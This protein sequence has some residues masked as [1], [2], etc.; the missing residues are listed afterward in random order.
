MAA[1][2]ITVL[3]A[4]SITVR[5]VHGSSPTI[6]PAYHHGT[7]GKPSRP[8]GDS[9]LVLVQVSEASIKAE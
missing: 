8:P 7:S 6:G 5:A 3:V 2:H 9:E 1:W 4:I